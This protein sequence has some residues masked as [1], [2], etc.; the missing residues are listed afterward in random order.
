VVYRLPRVCIDYGL[1][2]TQTQI[3]VPHF[4]DEEKGALFVE[5]AEFSLDTLMILF[6]KHIVQGKQESFKHFFT[7]T[8]VEAY[9][10]EGINSRQLDM[11]VPDI[12][13]DYSPVISQ[14]AKHS[15][16]QTTVSPVVSQLRQFVDQEA[17]KDSHQTFQNLEA[18]STQAQ[19]PLSKF[20]P[21]QSVGFIPEYHSLERGSAEMIGEQAESFFYHFMKA[22]YGDAFSPANWVSSTRSKFFPTEVAPVSDGLG[23]DFWFERELYEVKGHLNPHPQGFNLTANEWRVANTC[24]PSTFCV[25][26]ISLYP[27]PQISYLYRNL[28]FC[29][30]SNGLILEPSGY[31]VR[32]NS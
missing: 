20:V 10:Q 29:V 28:P 2:T 23:Y 31:F 27:S 11:H 3:R 26:G 12:A 24:A 9:L 32:R 18:I 25:V 1:L 6:P 30:A 8:K 17:K 21:T 7:P 13:M 15:N 22:K 16:Q 5:S 19:E 14:T 4:L